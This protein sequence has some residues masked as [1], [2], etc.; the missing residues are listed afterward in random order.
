MLGSVNLK[1]SLFELYS[2]NFDINTA[3]LHSFKLM[4]GT[5]SVLA[6][7]RVLFVLSQT[8]GDSYTFNLSIISRELSQ[9]NFYQM[10]SNAIVQDFALSFDLGVV[11]FYITNLESHRLASEP[12]ELTTPTNL[13]GCVVVTSATV[14]Q[15]RQK[16]SPESLFMK[17]A[18]SEAKSHNLT[19]EIAIK[20]KLD[21]YGLYKVD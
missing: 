4:D 10:P 6:S 5:S 8:D 16:R 3:P 20:Y 11:G 14:Y 2:Y 18:L 13:G 17:S 21:I 7:E 15:C 1:E 19:D 9:R 12:R